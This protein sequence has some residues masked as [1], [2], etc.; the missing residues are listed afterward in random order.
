[1]NALTVHIFCGEIQL[2]CRDHGTVA[3]WRSGVEL[4]D[5]GAAEQDH[6]AEH[7]ARGAA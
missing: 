6:A 1:M 2:R 4:A 5:I 7:V 3:A